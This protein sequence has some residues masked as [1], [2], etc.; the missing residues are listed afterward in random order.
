MGS[1]MRRCMA[2]LIGTFALVF[3]GTGSVI[4]NDVSPGAVTLV[5]VSLAFGLVIMAM[6]YS[7]GDVSGAHINPAVTVGFW[8]ARRFPGR[9]VI[10]YIVAQLIGALVASLVLH[11]MYPLHTGLGA[12]HPL[13]GA[14]GQ[15]FA[16]EIVLTFL[17]MFVILSVACGSKEQGLMAGIAIGGVVGFEVLCGGPI[18]GASMNP[19]RS[20]GPA[21]VSRNLSDLWIYLAAPLLGA[22]IAVAAWRILHPAKAPVASDA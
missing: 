11:G 10:F 15:S 13:H 17:L 2:E 4:V 12:T 21:V 5:G 22:A 18:S 7:I 19:A 9:D 20:F 3:A 6:I 1:M 14:I 16:L 8:L